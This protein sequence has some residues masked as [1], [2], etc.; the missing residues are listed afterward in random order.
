M[1]QPKQVGDVKL[2]P[3]AQAELKNIPVRKFM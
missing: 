3:K 2:V 1:A